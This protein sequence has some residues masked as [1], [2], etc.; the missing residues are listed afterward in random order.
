MINECVEH[1]ILPPDFN[2]EMSGFM[3]SMFSNPKSLLSRKGYDNTLIDIVIDTLE[4]GQTSNT[5]VRKICEVSKATATRYL[6]QLE[7]IILS[8]IGETGRG[9][10]YIIKGLTKGSNKV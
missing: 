4:Q 1:E 9:T 8:R 10:H 6:D 5:R 3:V 2:V 7:G